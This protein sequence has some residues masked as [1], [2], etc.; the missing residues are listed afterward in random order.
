[1]KVFGNL[2]KAALESI[3]GDPSG[4]IQG[5]VHWD[6]TATQIKFDDGTNKYALLRNDEKLIIGNNGTA[7]SNVRL[8]RGAAAVLQL[9]PGNN[10]TADGTLATSLAQF[11]TRFE[12]YTDAGKP[13][14]GN[15]GRIIWVTDLAQFQGDDGAA[16]VPFSAAS[17]AFPNGYLAVTG[18]TSL[19]NSDN[20]KLI[21]ITAQSGGYTIT[22]PPHAANQLILF[23]EIT[24][25]DVVSNPITLARNGGT[26]KIENVSADYVVRQNNFSFSLFDNGTDW[27]IL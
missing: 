7:A 14:A 19:L 18:T 23:K 15:A 8:H 13:A 26:G 20:L 25:A 11:S 22:L 1:M 17:D 3:A 4:N 9:V 27:F 16:W 6:T 24:N 2:E 21:G 5:R 10:A 12:N